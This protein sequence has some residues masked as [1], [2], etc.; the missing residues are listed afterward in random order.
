MYDAYGAEPAAYTPR[1]AA[2][3]ADP[4]PAY[5]G[6]FAKKTQSDDLTSPSVSFQ[7]DEPTAAEPEYDADLLAAIFR[8]AEQGTDQD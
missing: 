5:T 8:E 2:S 6:K 1:S 7:Q 3:A 4:A